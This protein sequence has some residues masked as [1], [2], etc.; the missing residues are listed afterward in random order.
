MPPRCLAAAYS[1]ASFLWTPCWLLEPVRPEQSVQ[2]EQLIRSCP[3]RSMSATEK[4]M[5]TCREGMAA[6]RRGMPCQLPT[7]LEVY[8]WNHG[9]AGGSNKRRV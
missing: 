7:T 8:T 2:L 4:E 6:C 5:A 3:S 9:A 1:S